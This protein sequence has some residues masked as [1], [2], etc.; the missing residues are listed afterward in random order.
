[1]EAEVPVPPQ[2]KPQPLFDFRNAEHGPRG[3]KCSNKRKLEAYEEQV[4]VNSAENA[5]GSACRR[6]I[7]GNVGSQCS[8]LESPDL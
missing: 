2:H 7:I 3:Y 6:S 8:Q 4:E 5:A 1:M